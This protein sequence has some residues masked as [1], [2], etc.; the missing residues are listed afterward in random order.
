LFD[1]H[2]EKVRAEVLDLQHGLQFVP[3]A[4]YAPPSTG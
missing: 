4:R 3:P 2:A 1:R